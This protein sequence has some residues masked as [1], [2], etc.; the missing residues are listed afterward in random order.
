MKLLL[1]LSFSLALGC[2]LGGKAAD[3]SGD[4]DPEDTEDV[5][6]TEDEDEDTEDEED[7]DDEED[8]EEEPTTGPGVLGDET[9]LEAMCRRFFECG[10]GYYENEEECMQAS[11]DY[12]GECRAAED[13]LNALGECVANVDCDDYNPD[14]YNPSSVGCDDEWEDLGASDC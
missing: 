9:G 11:Y 4:V 5:D 10:G 2:A 8:T 6:D 14:S 13:A 12:W 7:T 1:L 3:K